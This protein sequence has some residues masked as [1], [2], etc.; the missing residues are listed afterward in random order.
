VVVPADEAGSRRHV[1]FGAMLTN[2]NS[3]TKAA[4][5]FRIEDVVE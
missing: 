4:A 2:R 5:L 1:Y 3:G